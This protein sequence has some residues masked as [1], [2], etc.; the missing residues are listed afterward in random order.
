MIEPVFI[1]DFSSII[2]LPEL[3]TIWVDILHFTRKVQTEL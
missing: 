3:D 1:Q 2:V